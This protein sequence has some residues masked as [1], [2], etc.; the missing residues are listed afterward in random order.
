MIF[1]HFVSDHQF[2]RAIYHWVSNLHILSHGSM[3]QGF[4]PPLPLFGLL[5]CVVNNECIRE[6]VRVAPIMENMVDF[7]LRWFGRVEKAVE[8]PVKRLD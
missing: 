1:H 4:F 3:S 2:E 8:A 5:C 6:K 7:L